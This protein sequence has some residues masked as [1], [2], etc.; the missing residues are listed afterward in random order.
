LNSITEALAVLRGKRE[1]T[2]DDIDTIAELS[3]W[4]NYE[5]KEL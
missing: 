2:Q 1:V 3:N 4:I 5:F